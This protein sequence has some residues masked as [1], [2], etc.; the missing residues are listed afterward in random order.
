M[1]P[2]FGRLRYISVLAPLQDPVTAGR[3]GLLRF[4]CRNR[5]EPVDGSSITL[6]Q[7]QFTPGAP[8]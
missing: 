1:T 4:G 2:S 3:F 6:D 5:F 8:H 7:R